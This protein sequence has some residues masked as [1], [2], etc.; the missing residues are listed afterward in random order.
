[1]HQPRRIFDSE[2]FYTQLSQVKP[3]PSEAGGALL[4]RLL[5]TV[6]LREKLYAIN[7]LQLRGGHF[8][9]WINTH[10]HTRV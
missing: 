10:A 7:C 3:Q 8:T 9:N 1:M 4:V 5:T 6:H 2:S